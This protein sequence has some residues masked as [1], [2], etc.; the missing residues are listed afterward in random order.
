MYA[1]PRNRQLRSP[2]S[3]L[4]VELLSHIFNLSTHA[5]GELDGQPYIDEK[6]V[7][8]PLALSS[9]NWRW[10]K[11]ALRAEGLW[12]SLCITPITMKTLDSGMLN[13]AHVTSYLALSRNYPLNIAISVQDQDWDHQEPEIP[14]ENGIELYI[15]PMSSE[16][17]STIVS[18]LIPHISR[19]KS[20]CITTDTWSPMHTALT[21]INPHIVQFG[22]PLLEALV[23]KR[24][25]NRISYSP[26]FQPELMKAPAFLQRDSTTE[27][28]RDMLPR[29]KHVGL[30]GVHVD[31]DSLTDYLLATGS[32]LITLKMAS[33]CDDVRPSLGQFHKLLS[34]SPGILKLLVMGSGFYIGDNEGDI[35]YG[36]VELPDLELIIIAYRY[37]LDEELFVILNGS[38]ARTLTLEDDTNPADP[39]KVDASRM[40]TLIGTLSYDNTEPP[41]QMEDYNNC[42][43][44]K[45]VSLTLVRVRAS[46]ASLRAFFC[47]LAKLE[48]LELSGE[49]LDA[50]HALLPALPSPPTLPSPLTLS[51]PPTLPSPIPSPAPASTNCP[52]SCPQLRYLCIRAFHHLPVP[53]LQNL[54]IYLFNSALQHEGTCGLREVDIHVHAVRELP[55][56]R[57]SRTGV[58]GM[59]VTIFYDTCTCPQVNHG[60]GHGDEDED[61]DEDED[62]GVPP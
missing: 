11:V 31:W 10:R 54:A 53:H 24:W 41:A 22:A 50:V 36:V 13:T 42:M 19:W 29:L 8:M 4:P 61:E 27:A 30:F 18:L 58:R 14:S 51:P 35:D 12:S 52:C 45:L 32:G 40:L 1:H 57:E 46:P 28:R 6:S 9:V 59:K 44:P 48:R 39:E 15:P 25:N 47:S 33:H 2:I 38:N 49:F 20:L 3:H 16:H 21:S 23:L 43:F 17:M 56:W 34:S 37:A 7:G 62:G 60:H 55:P 26:Q 5:N